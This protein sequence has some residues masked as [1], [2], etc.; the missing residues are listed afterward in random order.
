MD[1]MGAGRD[2][3]LSAKSAKDLE[4]AASYQ[5]AMHRACIVCHRQ[6]QE[7]G[8]RKGLADCSTCHPSLKSR[9]WTDRVVL[10]PKWVSKS[11]Q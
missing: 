5:T 7:Q 1:D 11:N 10:N 9:L 6:E 4:W 2:R 8:N 3:I